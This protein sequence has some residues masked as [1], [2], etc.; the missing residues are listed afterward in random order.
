MFHIAPAHKEPGSAYGVS[1]P[2]L[3]GCISA[4]GGSFEDAAANP[5]ATPLS[6]IR[7]RQV[8]Q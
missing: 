8:W 2:D 1:F 4:A 3:P 5:G 7:S 6:T